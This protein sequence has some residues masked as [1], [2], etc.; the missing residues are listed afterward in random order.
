[1]IKRS[2]GL[3]S[4]FAIMFIGMSV[5]FFTLS[6]KI[7]GEFKTMSFSASIATASPGILA[8]LVGGFLTIASINS[9]DEFPKYNESAVE[10]YL[11]T[12]PDSL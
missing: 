12:K 7:N 1:M 4:G 2:V 9:K 3:F 8:I 5:V 11:P 10:P 6:E